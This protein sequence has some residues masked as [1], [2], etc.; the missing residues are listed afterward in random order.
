MPLF[1]LACSNCNVVIFDRMHKSTDEVVCPNCNHPLAKLVSKSNFK[2][3][4]GGWA[5]DGYK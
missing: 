5:E 3:K 4:G 2:L 1:D